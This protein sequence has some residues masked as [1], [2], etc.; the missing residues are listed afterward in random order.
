MA[1]QD[2][3]PH[4]PAVLMQGTNNPAFFISWRSQ[5]E[6]SEIAGLEIGRHDLGRPGADLALPLYSARTF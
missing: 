4:P 1:P 5:K 3:D 6:I 2:F